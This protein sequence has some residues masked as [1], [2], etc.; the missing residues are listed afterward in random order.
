M[1]TLALPIPEAELRRRH[2]AGESVAALH[3]LTGLPTSAVRRAILSTGGRLRARAEAMRLAGLASR[4]RVNPGRR[5]PD[6]KA[7]PS[8]ACVHCGGPGPEAPL[9][10]CPPCA[11]VPWVRRVYTARSRRWTPAWEAHLRELARRAALQLP[12]FP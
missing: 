4:G 11:A 5:R 6:G 7:P 1:T 12:L 8:P 3:R 9:W 2:E 10:L